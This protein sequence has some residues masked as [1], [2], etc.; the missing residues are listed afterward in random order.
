MCAVQV[1]LFMN[2][3]KPNKDVP[4]YTNEPCRPQ[5]LPTTDH[6]PGANFGSY[7]TEALPRVGEYIEFNMAEYRVDHIIHTVFCSKGNSGQLAYV[8]VFVTRT[9][10]R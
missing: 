7:T 8:K 2:P 5:S 9:N 10:W 4:Y 1:N 3:Y 6:P